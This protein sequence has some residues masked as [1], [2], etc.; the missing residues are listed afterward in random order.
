M[1]ITVIGAGR[2]GSSVALNCSLRELGDTLLLDIV[3]GLPQGEAMDINHQ[4][5]E[6]GIDCIAQGSNNYEDMRGSDFVIVVAGVGRKPGMTRMD[7]LKTNADI[8][9]AVCDKIKSYAPNSKIIVVTN[10]LDPLTYL[11]LKSLGG[12]RTQIMGMGG[13]LDLSRF[14]EHI[15]TIT[16]ISRNSVQ[17]MVI[18]EHGENMLPLVRFSSLGGIPLTEF[19]SAE[20]SEDLTNKIKKI[21][22]EVISLKGATVY[23]PGNAVSTMVESIVKNKKTIL[24]VSALLEGEYGYHDV[25][26]GVP[27]VLG[28]NGAEKIIELKLNESEMKVFDLGVQSVKNAIKSFSL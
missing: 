20:Q 28:H 9:M 10:P 1:K 5:A 25:C 26:I 18:S 17:A 7:L 2:V 12:K 14:K 4:L 19:I 3:E 16:G 27:C 6:R 21:A 23:A 8:V 11:V 15:S 13:M 22:A 24:P